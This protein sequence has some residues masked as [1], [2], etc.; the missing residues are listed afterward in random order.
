MKYSL[1]TNFKYYK[2]SIDELHN[3]ISKTYNDKNHNYANRGLHDVDRKILETIKQNQNFDIKEKENKEVKLLKEDIPNLDTKYDRKY[4]LNEYNTCKNEFTKYEGIDYYPHEI[5]WYK[6]EINKYI[7]NIDTMNIDN[8]VG[9]NHITNVFNDLNKRKGYYI[10]IRMKYLL[11]KYFDAVARYAFD[12]GVIPDIE[13]EIEPEPGLK[14]KYFK[15]Y[16]ATIDEDAVINKQCELLL[17]NKQ[18]RPSNSPWASPVIVVINKDGTMRMCVDY[19]YI[20]KH[21]IRKQWPC[22]DIRRLIY[23]FNG[24]IIFSMLDINK[25]FHN[26]AVAKDSIQYTSFITNNGQYEFLVMP[27]GGVNCPATWAHATDL[28]FRNIPDLKKYVDDFSV[29]SKTYTAHFINL[30]L[31]L[32]KCVQNNLKLKINKCD[33]LKDRIEFVGHTIDANGVTPND[34]YLKHIFQLKKPSNR[35]EFLSFRSTINYLNKFVPGLSYLFQSLKRLAKQNHKWDW[36]EQDDIYFYAIQHAIDKAPKLFH[37]DYNKPFH[38][39]CDSSNYAG[40]AGLYQ[41]RNVDGKDIEVPIEYMSILYSDAESKCHIT[42][43]ELVILIKAIKKWRYHLFK[44]FNVFTDAKCVVDLFKRTNTPDHYSNKHYRWATILNQYDFNVHHVSGIHNI[45]EDYL[46][47]YLNYDKI[48][49]LAKQYNINFGGAADINSNKKYNMVQPTLHQPTTN[50]SNY[51]NNIYTCNKYSKS[52]TNNINYIN[53]KSKP[54]NIL[55]IPKYEPINNKTNNIIKPIYNIKPNKSF[56]INLL[57]SIPKPT[58]NHNYGTTNKINNNKNK[59][60]KHKLNK[61]KKQLQKHAQKHTGIST[62]TKLKRNKNNLRNTWANDKKDEDYIEPKKYSHLKNN[63]NIR[64]SK[65]LKQQR[66]SN[67]NNNKYNFSTDEEYIDNNNK[68]DIIN[69][70]ELNTLNIIDNEHIINVNSDTNHQPI[71]RTINIKTKKKKNKKNK[72]RSKHHIENTAEN[73]NNIDSNNNNINNTFIDNEVNK[74][75]PI[76]H[77]IY[78]NEINELEINSN[79]P[80]FNDEEIIKHNEKYIN[81]HRIYPPQPIL[82]EANDKLIIDNDRAISNPNMFDKSVIYDMQYNYDVNTKLIIDKITGNDI[83]DNYKSLHSMVIKDIND[84]RYTLDSNKLLIYKNKFNKYVIVIPSPLIGSYLKY[85]HESIHINIHPGRDQLLHLLQRQ[86]HWPGMTADVKAYTKQCITCCKIKYNQHRSIG[87]LKLHT[88][89]EPWNT[90]QIDFFGPFKQSINGYIFGT[91]MRDVYHGQTIFVPCKDITAPTVAK[92]IINKWIMR[93][94]HFKVLYSDNGKQLISDIV[95][96]LCNTYGIKKK[97]TTYYNPRSDGGI[98]RS[99]QIVKKMIKLITTSHN[100]NRSRWCEYSDIIEGHI[101]NQKLASTGIEPNRITLGRVNKMPT[102]IDLDIISD[103]TDPKM[104]NYIAYMDIVRKLNNYIAKKHRYKYDTQRK[105][106]YD[107]NKKEIEYKLNEYVLLY[108]G[109]RD[110]NYKWIGP[111]RIT[112]IFNNGLNYKLED[113]NDNE[114]P[115]ITATV[116]QIKKY[117]NNDLNINIEPNQSIIAQPNESIMNDENQLYINDDEKQP[118]LNKSDYHDFQTNNKSIHEPLQ[119]IA[120]EINNINTIND[121]NINNK[122][123]PNINNEYDINNNLIDNNQ[124]NQ[125]DSDIIIEDLIPHETLQGINEIIANNKLLPNQLINNNN[126]DIPS[127]NHQIDYTGNNSDVSLASTMKIDSEPIINNIQPYNQPNNKLINNN[128][129]S[130]DST[131][132]LDNDS[133]NSLATTVKIEPDANEPNNDDNKSDDNQSVATT[134]KLDTNSNSD[135]DSNDSDTNIKPIKTQLINPIDPPI[136]LDLSNVINDNSNSNSNKS[137]INDSNNDIIDNISVPVN[138]NSTQDRMDNVRR[139]IDRISDVDNNPEVIADNIANPGNVTDEGNDALNEVLTD[140]SDDIF[141]NSVFDDDINI[142]NLSDNNNNN[143]NNSNSKSNINNKSL[144][145]KHNNDINNN[146]NNNIDIHIHSESKEQ[147]KSK[148]QNTKQSKIKNQSNKYILNKKIKN[149]H[150][151]R[152]FEE[153]PNYNTDFIEPPKNKRRTFFNF[154]KLLFKKRKKNKK[155][156]QSK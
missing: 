11:Y 20:N 28:A 6:N 147:N 51:L 95:K 55:H 54:C 125:N 5:K 62:K 25:A 113:I 116:Y 132:K 119:N 77:D 110:K 104:I 17:K 150:L 105:K 143:I 58:F 73:T 149:K 108:N 109:D 134:V 86:V 59:S 16:K 70:K 26:V 144:D 79:K 78:K 124:I 136:K 97:Y 68:I 47:R 142:D 76:P 101:N 140:D 93:Y 23:S 69:D 39:R 46:S 74:V 139:I 133:D 18:I 1:F 153:L 75:Q 156:N 50:Q 7:E 64:R 71:N 40:G 41:M 135:S 127:N 10:A 90:V 53:I 98:E 99:V 92:I 57:K 30:E 48:N 2:Q 151:K 87:E 123:Q 126:N 21:Q 24:S 83:T 14:P 91:M 154:K 85:F 13:Y 117:F 12:I 49:E 137:I 34:K 36:N 9:F 37:P 29:A 4:F 43:K 114:L 103:T 155:Q 45:P 84:K 31:I 94:G 33:I 15:P 19:S 145:Q 61:K 88:V 80:P 107:K 56:Y 81:K 67:N 111:Y 66:I 131:V 120:N 35:N 146:N 38:I 52:N 148:E 32:I 112:K 122:S 44:P 82:D 129:N 102:N 42:D 106:Y 63:K 115:P 89:Y 65:R 128:Y 130:D 27:F 121:N 100:I 118:E 8:K 3:I 72:N 152:K 60:I 96:H 141:E 22:P 138:N